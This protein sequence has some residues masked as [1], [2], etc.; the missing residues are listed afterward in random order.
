MDLQT[1]I[2]L[3]PSGSGKGT[4]VARVREYLGSHDTSRNIVELVMGDLFRVFWKKEG[5]AHDLSRDINLAGGLQPS[6]LQINM[7]SNFMLEHIRG[8]EHL[9]IDGS[10]RRTTDLEAMES[11]FEFYKR[12][13][14]TLVFINISKE[15]SVKRL[16]RRAEMA[17]N[18]R[19]EDGDILLIDNRYQWFLESVMPVID[20]M[21]KNDM[22]TVIEINGEQEVDA[23][24]ED[25]FNGLGWQH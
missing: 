14:P 17:E 24:T 19:P 4:Q 1:L 3:G 18:P 13:H 12:P 20:A 9:L 7:W 11:A 23:V 5:Y 15:E 8:N 16:L 6:F 25:V 2:F 10:P 21:R 22:F